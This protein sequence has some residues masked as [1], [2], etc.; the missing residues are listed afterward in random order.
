MGRLWKEYDLL[1]W[2]S[3][4][5]ALLAAALFIPSPA[6]AA[7][8][9]PGS[10]EVPQETDYRVENHS[11]FTAPWR[12]FHSLLSQDAE[13]KMF[14]DAENRLPP[15]FSVPRGLEPQVRFWLSI[16]TRYSSHEAVIFDEDHPDVVYDVL[17]FRELARISR[18]RA[19]FEIVSRKILKDR[20]SAY[21]RAFDGLKLGRRARARSPEAQRILQAR[22]LI[23]HQHSFSEAKRSLRVQWG[24][25]DQVMEGL[26]SSSAYLQRM[27]GIFTQMEIPPELVLLSLVESSFHWAAV[28]HAGATGVW[29]FMP[30]T[31]AEFMLVQTNGDID[32]RLSPI[33]STVAAGKLLKRNFRLLGNWPLAISAYNHGH[34]K[35]AR[36]KPSQWHMVPSILSQ[37]SRSKPLVKLGFASRNYYAEFLALMRA[38]RYQEIAYGLLP[39][40]RLQSVRFVL[41][42]RP[43]TLRELS[44][45][46]AV[47][48]AELRRLNPDIKVTA[49]AIPAGYWLSV[50]SSRDDFVGLIESRRRIVR[51]APVKAQQRVRVAE[52]LRKTI[53]RG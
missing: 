39:E 50:P 1:G 11:R 40:G 19:A 41:N 44:A 5:G 25:R 28:S 2:A 6:P 18:N 13:Q 35:W 24:Q 8:D 29:Q 46:H 51:A 12:L 4:R 45:L 36:L 48:E 32:E 10:W 31:G 34:T 33:K 42:R 43:S 21:E 20:F 53:P 37:C 38:Y 26:L 17:D 14:S 15:E 7:F 27:E 47:P 49:S 9:A 23:S 30:E 22:S 3:A 52:D 16:Y